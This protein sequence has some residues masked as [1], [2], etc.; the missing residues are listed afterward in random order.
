MADGREWYRESESPGLR[1][2]AQNV[3]SCY[4]MGHVA[5]EICLNDEQNVF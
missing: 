5:K 4:A 3:K 2:P 1:G